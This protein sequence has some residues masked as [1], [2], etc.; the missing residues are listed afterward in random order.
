MESSIVPTPNFK[1][2]DGFVIPAV[3]L[4]A[5]F[6]IMFG[7]GRLLMYRYQCHLRIDR[8]C[9]IEKENA[10][11]SMLNWL[12]VN[13]G[14]AS[15]DSTNE[16]HITTPSGREVNVISI[17]TPILF[18]NHA[19]YDSNS[20][21]NHFSVAEYMRGNLEQTTVDYSVA[22]DNFYK[23]TIGR[24]PN[25]ELIGWCDDMYSKTFGVRILREKG[26]LEP[27]LWYNNMNGERGVY[28]AGITNGQVSTALSIEMLGIGGWWNDTYGRRYEVNFKRVGANTRFRMYLMRKNV[29]WPLTGNG[30]ALCL[31]YIIEDSEDDEKNRMQ[32]FYFDANKSWPVQ[33]K[34]HSGCVTRGRYFDSG[35]SPLSSDGPKGMQLAGRHLSIYG[36]SRQNYIFSKNVGYIDDDGFYA[37]FTNQT[38]DV[39]GD[40]GDLKM[41]LEVW[42]YDEKRIGNTGE[43]SSTVIY[44]I[45]VRPA[46][47]FDIYLEYPIKPLRRFGEWDPDFKLATVVQT[48]MPDRQNPNPIAIIYDTPGTENK[49]WRKDEREAEKKR[50]G[51]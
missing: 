30:V 6:G 49:G 44:E 29:T 14:D 28:F 25:S 27:L 33:T 2:H 38:N 9:E 13:S 51:W 7:V 36:A 23:F 17:P 26:G 15:I 22:G 20:H 41:V 35:A 47:K 16:L 21:S 12:R 24:N 8:Q 31:E 40:R 5:L 50:N 1:A 32:A 37:A 11:K 48:G 3:L 34:D 39:L 10:V 45:E 4:V 19:T 43:G 18:P 46:Y 42:P